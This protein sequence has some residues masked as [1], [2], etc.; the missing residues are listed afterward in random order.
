MRYKIPAGYLPVVALIAVQTLGALT[1]GYAWFVAV[2]AVET[3]AALMPPRRPA[4]ASAAGHLLGWFVNELPFAA[5][6]WLLAATLAAA[7]QGRLGSPGGLAALGLAVLT[8]G[9][10]AVIARRALTAGPAVAHALEREL[11]TGSRPATARLASGR[12]PGWRALARIVFAPLP[13]WPRH[14]Q[15]IANIR[16]GNAGRHNRLDLYR[17]RSY[18][19]GA[20]VLIHFHG[21]GFRIGAKSRDALPLLHRLASQGW[22]CISASYRLGRAGQ[23][24]HSLTDAKK[25]IAWVR[26]HGAAYGAD[27]SVLIVAG[28]SAGAHLAAMAALT[29]GDPAF[30]PG[31]EQ[32]DTSVSAAVCLYGYY[33]DREPDGPRPSSPRAY[34]RADAPPFLIAHGA[35]DPLLPASSA[36]SFADTLRRVSASPV[37]YAQLPAAQHSFDLFHSIRF[38]QVIDGIQAFTAWV[39]SARDHPRRRPPGHPGH[40]A[41][42]RT[43]PARPG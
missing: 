9:G 34:A 20:P 18:P 12:L 7:A 41:A 40:G 21:G 29:P 11:G 31:F 28:S 23:F 25:V 30:Q 22:V 19:A 2:I 5:I 43:R 38:E 35:S 3:L 33:G 1:A 26:Q 14:V 10:Q 4:L 6:A 24:P 8:A 36:A 15:R 27:P 16:Y 32:A 42:M 13:L 39:L 37:V 17:H